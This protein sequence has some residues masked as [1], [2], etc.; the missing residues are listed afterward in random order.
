M[1]KVQRYAD[2]TAAHIQDWKARHGADG[3]SEVLV[4]IDDNTTARFV[5]CKP[6]RTVMDAVAQHGISKNVAGSN[7]ALISNCVL[8]GDMEL[9]EKDGGVYGEVLKHINASI[10]AYRTEVKKL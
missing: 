1:E 9:L 3:L 7:K 2:I 4:T 6:G 5:I 8:G 10:S